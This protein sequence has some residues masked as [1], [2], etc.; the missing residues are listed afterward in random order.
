[1]EKDCFL[2][3]AHEQVEQLLSALDEKKFHAVQLL[4]WVYNEKVDVFSD[5]TDLSLQLREKLAGRFILRKL[6][7]KAKRTS[8]LDNTVRYTFATHDKLSFQTVLLPQKNRIS[9]CL[10]TQIGC[11]IK[12]SFCASGKHKFVRNL[13]SG[14]I[15][16]QIVFIQKDA[17]IKIDSVLF[18][19]MGEPLLN[20]DNVVKA[21]KILVDTRYFSLSRRHIVISTIGFVPEINKLSK[22]KLGVRL[23]LSLHAPDDDTRRKLISHRVPYSVNE[24]LQAGLEYSRINKSRL[25]I[26]YVL[27]TGI[28]DDID[29][30]KKLAFLIKRSIIRTDKIQINLIPCNPT[31]TSIKKI[32][33]IVTVQMFKNY[34]MKENLLTIIRQSRGID[35]GAACGQLTV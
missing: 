11:N 16:E 28:N 34:L 14:E 25:T 19:G 18:M 29:S 8:K 1:M 31:E 9:I 13:S 3:L 20:Y 21:I 26:E 30:A 7:L 15:L 23:A 22:E 32:P 10:S 27:I 33:D 12:C 2:D 5:C 4:K 17:G 35:I 24:I 6:A